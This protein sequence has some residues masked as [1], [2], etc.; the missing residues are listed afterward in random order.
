M[1]LHFGALLRGPGS[2]RAVDAGPRISA[3]EQALA[4]A[5]AYRAEAE[6]VVVCQGAEIDDL[7]DERD[8]LRAELTNV[9]S[10]LAPYLAAEA[11]AGAIT[12]PEMERDTSAIEDQATAPIEVTTLREQ[13][14]V[15]A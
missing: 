10:L 12:V 13:F 11:T 1:S 3:L 15:N 14:G 6:I 2:H 4:E 5:N 7:K 8:Q 9:R